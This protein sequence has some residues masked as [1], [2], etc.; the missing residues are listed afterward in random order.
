MLIRRWPFVI[1]VPTL[2]S[3]SA[4]LDEAGWDGMVHWVDFYGIRKKEAGKVAIASV[5]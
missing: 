2:S 5:Q 4:F 1:A 3:L